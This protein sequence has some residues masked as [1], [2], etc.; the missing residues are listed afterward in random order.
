[1]KEQ[2]GVSSAARPP[3][4]NTLSFVLVKVPSLDV[5]LTVTGIVRLKAPFLIAR[6]SKR[7]SRIAFFKSTE[8]IFVSFTT[9]VVKAS[10]S[11][12][13]SVIIPLYRELHTTSSVHDEI[14][15]RIAQQLLRMGDRKQCPYQEHLKLG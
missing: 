13:V 8:P 9:T 3:T 11:V 4:A 10:A 6:R 7:T 5:A 2:V 14:A 12:G 15:A 1:M